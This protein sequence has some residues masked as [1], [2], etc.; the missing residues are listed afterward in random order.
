MPQVVQT[1]VSFSSLLAGRS[2]ADQV[3]TFIMLFTI[4]VI[5]YQYGADLLEPALAKRATLAAVQP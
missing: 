1:G 4:R 2:A 5:H 3:R